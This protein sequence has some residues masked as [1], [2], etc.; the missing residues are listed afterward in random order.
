M[1]G[2][3]ILGIHIVKP[4]Y[5]K[6]GALGK[7]Y[8]EKGKYVYVGSAQNSLEKRIA[9]HLSKNKK[10]RWHIDYLLL[11][12]NVFVKKVFYKVAPRSEEEKDACKILQFGIPIKK[13]GSSDS[14]CVSH[15]FKV[16]DFDFVYGF[17]FTSLM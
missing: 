6:I 11:N 14:K 2:V 13:F 17:G 10:T 16:N 3:Y 9:R 5:I 12:K 4:I 15:L 8:F 7:I 1:K